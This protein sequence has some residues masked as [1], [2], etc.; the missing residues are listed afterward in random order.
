[1]TGAIASVEVFVSED[2]GSAGPRRRLTL[3]LSAPERGSED[4]LWICRVALANLHRPM[5]VRG[6]DSVTALAAAL[7]QARAWLAALDAQGTAL[8]RERTGETRF[9]LD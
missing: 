3:T 1:M 9:A 6:A 4:G 5:E 2:G 7:D 8:F